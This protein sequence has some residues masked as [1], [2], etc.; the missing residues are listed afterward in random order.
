MLGE[1]KEELN[2]EERYLELRAVALAEAQARGSTS[3]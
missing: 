1:R 3:G 2:R